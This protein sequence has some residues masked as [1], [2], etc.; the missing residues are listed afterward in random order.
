[1][2]SIFWHLI[3]KFHYKPELSLFVSGL[4]NIYLYKNLKF[5]V[6]ITA[7]GSFLKLNRFMENTIGEV[8]GINSSK[9]WSIENLKQLKFLIL[10]YWHDE[11][12]IPNNIKLE[13][14]FYTTTKRCT[15][16]NISKMEKDGN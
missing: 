11:E 6:S 15:K 2:Y 5:K 8:D 1:M 9:I 16:K 14:F 3:L 12:P 7:Q 13:Y 4:K 10:I